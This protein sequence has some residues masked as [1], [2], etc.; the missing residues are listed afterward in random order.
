MPE[1]GVS[2]CMTV[3]NEAHVLDRLAADVRAQTVKPDEIVVT[4]GGSTDGTVERLREALDEFEDVRVISMPG[5]NIAAGRNRAIAEARGEVVL[6]A[7]AGLRLSPRW[8]E[9]L[10]AALGKDGVEV[11]FGYVLSEPE[12][13][14]EFALAA[15]TRPLEA[16]IDPA[17]YPVSGGCAGFRAELF[18]RYQY[19][20]WLDYGEDMHLYLRWRRDGVGIVHVAAAN[21]G[22]RPR[23]DLG[24]FFRQYFNYAKGDGEVGMWTGRHGLRAGA[25]AVLVVAVGNAL[26]GSSWRL[27][28]ILLCVV[29]GAGYLRRPWQRLL[30]TTPV[31][32]GGRRV[33]GAGWLAVIRLVGDAAKLSGYVY[34]RMR[35]GGGR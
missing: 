28:T 13:D 2:L 3:K 23:P 4:D 31:W 16:E 34:G 1:I 8:V 15:V 25:Y 30:A 6:V 18:T 35:R 32:G 17:T 12:N 5:A 20:E 9:S 19:P 24:A 10:N 22:F 27:G 7:D 26:L 11:A 21:V 33:G 14:F 29:L